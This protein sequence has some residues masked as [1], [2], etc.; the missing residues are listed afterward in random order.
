MLFK[1][2]SYSNNTDA[3]TYV[4]VT[5]LSVRGIVAPELLDHWTDFNAVFFLST[6]FVTFIFLAYLCVFI[7]NKKYCGVFGTYLYHSKRLLEIKFHSSPKTKLRA[8][9][10]PA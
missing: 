2:I 7:T 5:G 9:V 1:I 6:L 8:L 3:L 10:V 4:C